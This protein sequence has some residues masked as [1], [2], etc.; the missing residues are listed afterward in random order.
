[1]TTV[2]KNTTIV[3]GDAHRTLL[4]GSAIVI[5]GDRISE[6]GDTED[7]QSRYPA[8]EIVDGRGKAVFP[9]LVNCHTHLLAVTD[10]GIL[11]DFGFPTTLG[12]PVTGRSML[13]PDERKVMALLAAIEAIR[14]GTTCLLEISS[15]IPEYADELANTGL[16]LVLAENINDFDEEDARRGS[17]RFLES[18]LDAGLQRST[19]LI[20]KWHG[21]ENG[22]VTCFIAPHAPENCSPNLLRRSREL[23]EERDLGYTIH[24]S[25]SH[26]EVEAVMRTRGVRPT[27]YLFANDLLG[28]RLVAAHCRYVDASEIAL[29][30]Q[31]G[32]AVSNNA[33]I[34]ARR[35][36]AAPAKE[37]LDAG[38][39]MGMGTDNMAEDMVEVMRT[40][41]F[42]ERVRRNDEMLPGPEDVLEWATSG[43]A[44]TL[45]M[46]DSI[47]SLEAGMKADLFIVDL[48]RSHL[49]PTN[50]VVSSFVHQGQPADITEVMVDGRWVM[51]DSKITAVDEADIVRQA[52]R[53]GHEAWSRVVEKY[54]DVP[55]PIRLPPRPLGD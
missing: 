48:M 43:G 7:I 8:A 29:L 38:C 39:N 34:A 53:I 41:L 36:A 1:M 25:Q 19:D 20:E 51:R 26:I 11:E 47:G 13:T 14:S 23:A 32:T 37:I 4:Y 49:V 10:R 6:I 17:Y 46:G 5:E 27:Q 40:G 54:P 18:K 24:L 31:T 55:F 12:F 22:R 2:I 52:E 15:D 50:H 33:A 21:R 42:A 9:G 3:T 44:R 16:R 35:G 45:G 30:G 28:P